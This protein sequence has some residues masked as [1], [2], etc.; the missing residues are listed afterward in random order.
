MSYHQDTSGP[1]DL[2]TEKA[3]YFGQFRP[4][5]N[6]DPATGTYSLAIRSPTGLPTDPP[7]TAYGVDQANDLARHLLQVDP[8]I[9]QIYSS[10]YYRCLQTIS[11][12]V[13]RLKEGA[14]TTAGDGRRLQ[15]PSIS[16]SPGPGASGG[17]RVEAGISEWYGLAPW[18]HPTSAP[19]P[20]LATLFPNSAIDTSY[21]SRV[22][23]PRHGESIAQLHERAAAAI[24]A[25]VEQSDREGARAIVLNTHAAVMIA[26]GR[27]LTGRM[28]ASVEE[29]DFKAFTC[30]L[31]IY[32][33]RRPRTPP[34][35]ATTEP[36]VFRA[37]S[38]VPY[39]SIQRTNPLTWADGSG[40]CGGWDCEADAD[41]SFLRGG[42]ERGWRFSGDEDFVSLGSGTLEDAR[43]GLGVVVEK[44]DSSSSN[45]QRQSG[46]EGDTGNNGK[47]KL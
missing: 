28:P 42:E 27:V 12:F 25:I 6:V 15:L 33:R 40:V 21:T 7:L 13:A 30:G 35:G 34:E 43:A 26:L 8:S 36:E 2:G 44:G 14:T 37:P 31:S 23:P 20:E 38:G 41:C 4:A 11:P 3:D 47:F 16:P 5:F 9:D 1:I 17:I 32:R 22:V 10:P 45:K 29:E 18:E 46:D 39:G 19:L 24:A